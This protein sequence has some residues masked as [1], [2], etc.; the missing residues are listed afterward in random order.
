[1]SN[2]KPVLKL[3]QYPIKVAVWENTSDDGRKYFS[4]KL[5]KTFKD[6]QTGEYKETPY[7][8]ER[9]LLTAAALLQEVWRNVACKEH[10]DKDKAPHTEDNIPF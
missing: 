1:M 3:E 8:S 4:T 7:L 5:V 10:I 2:N 6:K 9:D